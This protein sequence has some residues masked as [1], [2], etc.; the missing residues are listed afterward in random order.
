[1]SQ[2]ESVEKTLTMQKLAPC[3]MPDDGSKHWCSNCEL[4]FMADWLIGLRGG[5]YGD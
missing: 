5:E 3:G 4:E 2:N 1:M